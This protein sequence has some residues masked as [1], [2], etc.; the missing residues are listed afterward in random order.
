VFKT[1]PDTV[2]HGSMKAAVMSNCYFASDLHLFSSR[3][4]AEQ[5]HDAIVRTAAAADDFVLG[6]DIFDFHWSRNAT[7]WHALD[8]A[9]RWLESLSVDAPACRFHYILGNHDHVP[10]L[11]QRLDLLAAR[12]PNFAWHEYYLRTGNA[13]FLH[14]DVVERDMD[15]E[16]LALSRRNRPHMRRAGRVRNWIYDAAVATRI[17]V[18]IPYLRHRKENMARR[19]LRYL[20]HVGQGPETG[21]RNVY[22]GHTHLPMVDYVYSGVAFHNGGASIKGIP[23]HILRADTTA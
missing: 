3:S 19:I 20:R 12:E 13:V 11:M 10:A 15:P 23:F 18:P 16:E 14:G 22:F 8:A 21:L 1:L 2:N 17:H 5:Y 9:I 6:G 7:L 4:N